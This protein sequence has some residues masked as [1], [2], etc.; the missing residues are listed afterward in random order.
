MENNKI[1]IPKPIEINEYTYCF[2]DQLA[3][4]HFSYRCKF[5]TK[6]KITIKISKKEL[7]KYNNDKE[8]KVEYEITSKVTKHSFKL[9]NDNENNEVKNIDIAEKKN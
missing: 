3:N 6:C 8:Y 5:R 2:K 9:K 1:A 7:K 4:D